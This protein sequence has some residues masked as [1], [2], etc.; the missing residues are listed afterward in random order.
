M[1][2][3]KNKTLLIIKP[4]FLYDGFYIRKAILDKGFK[5]LLEATVRLT[6]EEACSFYFKKKD[7][8]FF[9]QL[10]DYMSSDEIVVVMLEKDNAIEEL[11]TLLGNVNPSKATEGTLRASFGID[12]MRN[13]CHASDSEEDAKR[14]CD[15]F[16]G[17]EL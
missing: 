3:F 17:L 15:F 14:E 2:K 5:I 12:V 7:K 9:S 10:T 4:G 16:F 11:K 8:F 6:K 1:K 13:V